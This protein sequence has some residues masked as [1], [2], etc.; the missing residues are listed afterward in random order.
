MIHK[1]IGALLICMFAMNTM[2]AQIEDAGTE[3]FAPFKA[4]L[5]ESKKFLADPILPKVENNTT[6]DVKY[7]VPTHL[8]PVDYPPPVIRPLAMKA[9]K[10]PQSYSF[11]AKAGIGYPLSPLLE[12]SYHS[13]NWKNLKFGVTAKHH[14]IRGLRENQNF[15][16]THLDVGAT[17]YTKKALAIGGSVGFDLNANKFYGYLSDSLQETTAAELGLSEDSLKQQFIHI[18]ANVGLFNHTINRGDFN[19]AG[20]VGLYSYNDRYG[21][22]EF[23]L[24]PEFG[25]EKWFG[26]RQK[27]PL[28][29]KVGMNLTTFNQDTVNKS[30]VLVYF[31][32]NFSFTAGSFKARLGVDLGLSDNKFYFFPDAE[33]S[34]GIAKGAFT[35]YA[36]GV[37]QI[38]QNNFRSFTRSNR[39][40]ISNPSGILHTRNLDL[41]GGLRGTIKNINYD[42]RAGYSIIQNLPIFMNDSTYN[43][44]RFDV[45]YDTAGVVFVKGALDFRL[46]KNLVLGADLTFNLYS[47][48][49]KYEKA[50]HLPALESNI[51]L[52][53]DFY[54]DAK[55]KKR[56]RKKSK[57]G[58]K[59]SNHLSLKAEFF[60]N[61]G[62]PYLD[63]NN[64]TQVL[65][66]LFDFSFGATYHF[67]KNIGLFV[68]V[69]NIINNKNQRWY[70]YPQVGFNVMGGA[71]V[72]F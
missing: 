56:G 59:E 68:D 53:Y 16:Q 9:D 17:Y 21:A 57:G 49:R 34:F 63:E 67:T 2:Y 36:G 5:A 25:I 51:Y 46:V 30:R 8:V 6:K 58:L 40:L 24:T 7:T 72:K 48:L 37:G 39:F 52:T 35:I 45:D 47:G 32:P 19:Y 11:Y 23:S 64:Q 15:G 10:L 66:G 18:E 33:L 4:K 60:I 50:F 61:T 38:Q 13:K 28:R 65:K 71:V 27:H 42:F 41:F 29:V 43:F 22:S 20:N 70:R 14:S 26:N 12:A 62:V 55:K 31:K 3:L 44:T 1:H 69:N 54:F